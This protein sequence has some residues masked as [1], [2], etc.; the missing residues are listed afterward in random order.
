M[1]AQTTLRRGEGERFRL[2]KREFSVASLQSSSERERE[3][4]MGNYRFRLSDMM[5]NAWFYKLKDVGISR[6]R[7]QNTSHPIKKKQSPTATQQNLSYY[8]TDDRFH[9][10][11]SPI[12]PKASDTHFPDPPRRSSSSN[13]RSTPRSSSP[14]IRTSSVS[15]ACSCR[16]TF[17]S[18]WN[19]SEYSSPDYYSLSPHLQSSPQAHE[20]PR[21]PEFWPTTD[22]FDALASWST[23]CSCR[24]TSSATATATAT[25]TDIIINMDNK[26]FTRNFDTIPHGLDQL[27]PILT[28][29]AKFNDMI[30]D[31]KKIKD[32]IQPPKFRRSSS[33]KLEE[34]NVRGS[35]SV[36]VVKD[37]SSKI[38][39]QHKTSTT[40]TTPIRRSSTTNS[41][42]VKLRA[43]SPR[44]ASRKIQAYS[45]KSM[46]SNTSSK[47][48]RRSHSE[49]FAIVKS[50]LDPQRDFRD[51]MVEMI[52]ENN[53]RASKDLEDL[54]AC[55]L[56]LNSKVYHN[57]IVKVFEQIW[58]DLADIRL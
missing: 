3:R 7:N 14:M 34:K 37:E 41:G 22:S 11:N 17:D 42:G 1:A 36:K 23:S 5:P 55:Y 50:S 27:P 45:R 40:T 30:R 9:N 28:K 25:A 38:L 6:S 10:N 51:S 32:T 2:K 43:N 20:S 49:N 47:S 56:S 44:I 13:R 35:L 18:V 19:M 8:F 57:L 31:I 21:L 26:S 12:N 16:A 33:K 48:S 53:I 15:A 46:S 54:L 24:L 58:F 39:K 52:V 4:C 29:P